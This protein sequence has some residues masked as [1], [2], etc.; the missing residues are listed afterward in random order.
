MSMKKFH[1][2]TNIEGLLRNFKR[3]KLTGLLED[4]N[5]RRLGD[6]EARDFLAE[7]QKKGWKL[8]PS[9]E[10]EGFDHFGGGCPGHEMKEKEA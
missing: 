2:A 1:M 6:K 9:A 3:R 10:C 8:L 5:G 7:C 4:E